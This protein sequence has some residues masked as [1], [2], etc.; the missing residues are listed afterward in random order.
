MTGDISRGWSIPRVK[1]I[2]TSM[3]GITG[4]LEVRFDRSVPTK[5]KLG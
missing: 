5:G 2:Y 3:E 1:H 4:V